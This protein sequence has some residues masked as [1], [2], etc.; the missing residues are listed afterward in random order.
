VLW[1]LSALAGLAGLPSLLSTAVAGITAS[2][3]DIASAT[4][5][6]TGRRAVVR[7]SSWQV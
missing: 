1:P 6:I 4:A 5:T 3:V 2:F 7:G